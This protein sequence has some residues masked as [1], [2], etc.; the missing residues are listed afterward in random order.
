[1]KPFHV[2]DQLE[3]TQRHIFSWSGSKM[4]NN[5]LLEKNEGGYDPQSPHLKIDM[6]ARGIHF[7][8]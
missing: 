3:F 2:K 5:W 7:I 4:T 8:T 1:M 6:E